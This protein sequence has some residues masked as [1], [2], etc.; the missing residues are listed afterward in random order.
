MVEELVLASPQIVGIDLSYCKWCGFPQLHALAVSSIL[1]IHR[2]LEFWLTGNSGL[3]CSC[4]AKQGFEAG[5]LSRGE[6]GVVGLP[7]LCEEQD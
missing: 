1:H 2:L 3:G 6:S 5:N 7:C 4:C